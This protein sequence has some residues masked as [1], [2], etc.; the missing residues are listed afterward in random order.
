[1]YKSKV[2]EVLW[3]SSRFALLADMNR[4]SRASS[5]YLSLSA[6]TYWLMVLCGVS[7]QLVQGT[8]GHKPSRL[9]HQL[10]LVLKWRGG[11]S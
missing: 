8:L 2:S 1:M 10:T 7:Q 6:G 5:A 3:S 11:G 9:P 4:L